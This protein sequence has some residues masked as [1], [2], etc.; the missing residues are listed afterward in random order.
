MDRRNIYAH[1]GLWGTKDSQNTLKALQDAVNLGFSVETDI[2]IY[3]GNLV[4]SH[5]SP[6]PD[7]LDFCAISQ[8]V[9][10]FALNIKEDGISGYA[11]DFT[12]W[13]TRSNSFFFDG[14]FPDMYNFK[15]EGLPHA[16][17]LSEYENSIPWQ[18][19]FIWVDCFE[20]DWWNLSD[21]VNHHSLT[22]KLIFVSPELH[23]RSNGQMW[24]KLAEL[25]N[26]GNNHI[27]ICTDYPLEFFNLVEEKYG[28]Q[29]N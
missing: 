17:R 8:M 4:I 21:L 2:R 7:A 14:S 28:N 22:S 12:D 11:K 23:G 15:K 27:G 18:T 20:S 19:D 13:L 26:L 24:C 1:R 3:G 16:L 25:I 10:S 6:K 9:G 5:D 29:Q